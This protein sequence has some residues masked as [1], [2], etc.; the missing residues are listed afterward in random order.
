M[1]WIKMIIN[2]EILGLVFNFIGSF[3]L[4]L[5][6]L[7]GKWHQ[8]NYTNH[9]TKRYWWMGWRPVFKV[10]PP[11]EKARWVIKWNHTVVR[12]GF[13]PPKHLWNSIGFLLITIGFFL[14]LLYLI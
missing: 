5:V 6:S 4:I 10:R 12:Q 11:N 14:Q 8:K 13:I 1:A 7:F 2:L 3:V 9:W